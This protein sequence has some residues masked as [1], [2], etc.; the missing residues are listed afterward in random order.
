VRLRQRF[1]VE[2]VDRGTGD[3]LV[4]QHADQSLLLPA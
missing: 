2:Y 4:L 1:N 3:S